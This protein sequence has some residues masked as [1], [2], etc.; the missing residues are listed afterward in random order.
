MRARIHP[1]RGCRLLGAWRLLPS[2]PPQPR[3]DD[4]PTESCVSGVV[5]KWVHMISRP[6]P[7]PP[8]HPPTHPPTPRDTPNTTMS[9]S[10]ASSSE[11]EYTPKNI[12]ITGGAGFM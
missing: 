11:A 10:K 7:P 6:F 12:L 2:A 5:A 8:T 1:R 9:A 4:D 3:N